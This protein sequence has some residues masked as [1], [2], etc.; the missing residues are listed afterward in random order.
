MYGLVDA[1]SPRFRFG[2]FFAISAGSWLGGG[3]WSNSMSV[4]AVPVWSCCWIES[5]L[6]VS[7]TTT[8]STYALRIGSVSELHALLRVNTISL[9]GFQVWIWYGPSET[10]C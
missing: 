9:V 5:W 3:A 2:S 6:T 10:S 1:V 4:L 8:L 7:L